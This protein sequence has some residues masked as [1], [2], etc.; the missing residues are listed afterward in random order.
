MKVRHGIRYRG[1][2]LQEPHA[3]FIIQ[4]NPL[5][6][7][8]VI[9]AV[10]GSIAGENGCEPCMHPHGLMHFPLTFCVSFLSHSLP[11]GSYSSLCMSS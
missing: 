5:G 7:P 8:E 9:N 3:D 4:Q 2:H 6:D 11:R 10:S 1:D